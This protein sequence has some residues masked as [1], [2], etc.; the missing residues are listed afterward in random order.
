MRVLDVLAL[1]RSRPGTWTVEAIARALDV[2][3]SS[4]YR[5]VKA[6]CAEGFLDRVTGGGYG[7]GP[8]FVEYDRLT[9]RAD[10][11]IAAA[12]RPMQDLLARTTQNATAVLCRRYCGTVMCVH[13]EHG[14]GPHPITVYERGVSMP[15]FAGATS[16]VVL[17]YLDE[18]TRRRVHRD[19]LAT[20]R[21]V[22]PE[23]EEWTVFHNQLAAIR[24]QGFAFTRSEVS[25]GRAAIAAPIRIGGSVVAAISLV[26][27][28]VDLPDDGNERFA[29][30]VIVSAEEIQRDACDEPRLDAQV[31]IKK[32]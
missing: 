28:E 21:G 5:S 16:K 9:R 3:V 32:T 4:A 17:A 19:N 18:R 24:R 8:A 10:A 11:L 14:T 22:S 13:Q 12:A 6:L 23:A 27:A 30:A 15:L 7:L 26:L 31:P 1:F 29:A 2:S 20:I 25:G